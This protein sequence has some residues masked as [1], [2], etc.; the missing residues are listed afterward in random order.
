MFSAT[1]RHNICRHCSQN[2][3]ALVCTWN[4]EP[5]S[6]DFT[7]IEFLYSSIYLTLLAAGNIVTVDFKQLSA[8]IT[9]EWC[10]AN[11]TA[12][13]SL[14]QLTSDSGD[15]DPVE[16][17]GK[18]G[19]VGKHTDAVNSTDSVWTDITTWSNYDGGGGDGDQEGECRELHF[20]R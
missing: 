7:D 16:N 9:V 1:L 19:A 15:A 20:V 17:G 4:K 12:Q 8:L 6:N 13:L 5:K 11:G 10:K 3:P 2:K 14:L 18:Y